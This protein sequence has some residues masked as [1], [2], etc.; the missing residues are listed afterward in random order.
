M[1][2]KDKFNLGRKYIRQGKITQG[3]RM[4]DLCLVQLSK[5]TMDGSTHLEGVSLDLWKTR[6][7]TA[8]EKA[9]LLPD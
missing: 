6:V 7:W 4:F 2:I 5:A 3:D 9:G 8:I 1:T